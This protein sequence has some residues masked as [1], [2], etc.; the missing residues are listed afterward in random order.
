MDD[1][2]ASRLEAFL[3]RHDGA[4]VAVLGMGN[5]LL[6]DDAVG[7]R[8][9]ERVA[10]AA[11]PERVGIPVGIGLENGFGLVARAQPS[12]LILCDAVVLEDAA[13]GT[14]D[15]FDPEN[16]DC[17][18]H[19]THSVP[20]PLF[21]RLW[22]EDLPGLEVVFLGINIHGA[23]LGAGLSPAVTQA[24]EDLVHRLLAV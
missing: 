16:L 21:V 7:H 17:A 8:L 12:A 6:G 3:A 18:I 1:G 22:K 13:P 24:C 9:A 14:W 4:V 19:S 5:P 20:L 11:R 10:A 2:A 23:P 15:L